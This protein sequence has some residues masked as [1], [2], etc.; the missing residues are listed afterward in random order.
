MWG[1]TYGTVQPKLWLLVRVERFI[2]YVKRLYQDREQRVGRFRE[3]EARRL[4]SRP[5]VVSQE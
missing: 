5:Q 4:S 3:E 1:Y 2:N